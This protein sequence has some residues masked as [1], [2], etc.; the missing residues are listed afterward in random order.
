MILEYKDLKLKGKRHFKEERYQEALDCYTEALK[1]QPQCYL[2]YSNR[3]AA[4]NKL[5][6][7][8]EA[9][10]DAI[11]CTSISPEFARGHY[12]K[13]SALNEVGTLKQ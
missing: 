3:S 8:E 11:R 2:L 4:H 5:K 13:A 12:R 1:L 7:Y 6:N 9:L 10:N